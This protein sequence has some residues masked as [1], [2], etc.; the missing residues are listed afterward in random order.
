ME[1][2]PRWGKTSRPG[3]RRT[4]ARTAAA[5]SGGGSYNRTTKTTEPTVAA[6]QAG[7][8]GGGQHHAGLG[9]CSGTPGR[10]THEMGRLTESAPTPAI[11][12]PRGSY[13]ENSRRS[14]GCSVDQTLPFLTQPPENARLGDQDGV[15][16]QAQ[17]LGH[18]GA[19][20]S[21]KTRRR[22]TPGRSLMRQRPHAS[23]GRPVLS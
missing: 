5:P 14:T 1:T 2:S 13:R 19:G 3:D 17:G 16:R 4:A 18:F 10:T 23:R 21:A 20:R 6:N 11:L 9:G 22:F 15:Y 8:H 7:A 12:S